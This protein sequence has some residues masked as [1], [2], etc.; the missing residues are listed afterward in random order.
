[1]STFLW[2]A[3]A[4]AAASVS[5]FAVAQSLR[6]G[7]SIR[8]YLLIYFF[9][10]FLVACGING[11]FT[12]Q[13]SFCPSVCVLGSMAGFSSVGLMI[14]LGKAL[15]KGP[16]GLTLAFLN[17][18]SI[19][20]PIL[21]AL[22]FK[23]PFGFTL[24]LGNL[25]GMVLVIL[26][27][28]WAAKRSSQEPFPKKWLFY[29]LFAFGFQ[30]LMLTLFQWR[31]LFI[32]EDLGSHL[33]IPFHCTAEDDLWFMPSM[34]FVAFLFQ[35]AF[36]LSEKRFPK[37][38][39]IKG[40]LVGGIA[41]ALSTFFLLTATTLAVAYEKTMLFPLFTVLVILLCNL[42]SRIL[43]KE[44]VHWKANACCALGIFIGLLF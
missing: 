5:S 2:V 41:N 8:G 39:E 40:G 12:F 1:M 9:I 35:L 13:H 22:I 33:L 7:A 27:L 29:T 17:S 37:M 34:F 30:V 25:F 32:K 21:M 18:S 23:A 44:A 19:V 26:G 20:P 15:H 11:L 3:L 42:C 38:V 24:T 28:F 31:S 10:C 14:L 36:F 6:K 4:A 16:P 43:Y